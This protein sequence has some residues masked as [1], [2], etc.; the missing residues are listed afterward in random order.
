MKSYP[1]EDYDLP[2]P[3]KEAHWQVVERILF[4]FA[5]MHP[6]VKYIQVSGYCRFPFSHNI[7]KF[8]GM[9]EIIGPIYYVLASDA[10]VEWQSL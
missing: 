10:N 3:G 7:A 2:E 6:A 4:L 8:Q 1:N 9:N 5:K